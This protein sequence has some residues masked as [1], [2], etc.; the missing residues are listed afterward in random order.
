MKRGINM[1]NNVAFSKYK[2]LAIDIYE[3]CIKHDLWGDNVIYF[4]GKA[5]AN[6][7][8]WYGENGKKI[9][10]D[11]YEYEDRNPKDYFEY[12]NP[13][14]LSMSFEGGLNHVLN[15]YTS[16]SWKLEEEFSKLF[17]KYGLYYELGNSWNLSA[18]EI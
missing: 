5:W 14:T 8:T 10:E 16:R 13:K 9:A 6:G 1:E 7:D 15:G 2:L 11:L 12:A 3:W 18:Y 4:D 17:K